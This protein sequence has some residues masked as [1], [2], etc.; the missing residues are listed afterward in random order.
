MKQKQFLR[1]LALASTIL[2]AG[3]SD[4]G[5]SPTEP[6]ESQAQFGTPSSDNLSDL[7]TRS[8]ARFNVDVQASGSFQPGKPIQLT[9][10]ARANLATR[11]AEVRL[12]LPEVAAAR[13]SSWETVEVPVEVPLPAEA[14][15]RSSL[16][17]GQTVRQQTSVTIP[18][19]GYY[20]VVASVLQR[21]D[22]PPTENGQL[23]QNVAHEVIWLWI[24]ENGGRVTR[25]FDRSLFPAG[26]RPQSGPLGSKR[27]PPRMRPRR[28]NAD[29]AA[30]QNRLLPSM[31]TAASS[32]S[33]M[34]YQVT[35]WHQDS[36]KY[37]PLAK[38]AAKYVRYDSQGNYYDQAMVSTAFD[39][40]V[41]IPCLQEGGLP[42]GSYELRIYLRSGTVQV[43]NPNFVGH[44]WGEFMWDCG[45]AIEVSVESS[46][47]HVFTNM[48]RTISASETF[49]SYRRP[50]IDVDLVSDTI[51]SY[52]PVSGFSG[53]C[54]RDDYIRIGT[55]TSKT[56]GPQVW[57]TNGVFVQAH[58]Y[59]HAFHEKALG[60]F[61]WYYKNCGYHSL[62][63]L[64][65]SMQCALPEGFANYYAVAT[66]GTATGYEYAW[67]TNYYY[68]T[69]LDRSDGS[70]SEAAI[71]AF[72]YDI[73]DSNR[74]GI[75]TPGDALDESHD[76]VS[77]P[78]SYVAD[79]IA[80]CKVQNSVDGPWYA[81]DG[82]DHVVYCFERRVDSAVTGS[83]TYFNSRNTDPVAQ[84]QSTGPS[85][86]NAIRKLWLWNL[87]H[88]E[89]T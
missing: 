62:T 30:G 43:N 9:V 40:T 65:A 33:E 86:P 4:D 36:A 19:P 68:V 70:K 81:N 38:A 25:E 5:E 6:S 46:P 88:R 64:A 87:Y 3:C 34:H 28:S 84:N 29:G 73:T 22:E 11:D 39:G 7:G 20:M 89:T 54:N 15:Q 42:S 72:L 57:G 61:Y 14:T 83:T 60:G 24:D 50:F 13:L 85:D 18:K 79:I 82:V 1:G 51:S 35:Y 27:A 32:A 80:N 78:G 75:G 59:G 10:T 37:V 44:F 23:V 69:F 17:R 41:Q 52:C 12:I 66:R 56:Y 31:T 8:L 55:Q 45:Y 16:V 48:N 26:A 53:R 2:V 49:F 71:A 67:E 47:S 63:A 76:A 74:W 77:Y 58:E 21:S